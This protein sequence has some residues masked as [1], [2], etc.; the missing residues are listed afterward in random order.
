MGTVVGERIALLFER[1][2]NG[3]V[4]CIICTASGGARMEEGMLALMQMAKTSSAVRR[5]V[6]TATSSQRADRSHD[7][8]RFGVVRVSSRRD[9]RRSQSLDRLRRPPR[10]RADDPSEASRQFPDRRIFARERRGRHGRRPPR[11]PRDARSGCSI[12][13]SAIRSARRTNGKMPRS[14]RR[15]RPHERRSS[16]G[17]RACSKSSSESPSCGEAQRKSGGRSLQRSVRSKTSTGRFSTRSSA[18]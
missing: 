18:R 5:F 4:S 16:N 11:S 17:R 2:A 8:R 14:L 6:A 10:H 15:K 9:R 13:P 1:R 7:R 3:S 12:T